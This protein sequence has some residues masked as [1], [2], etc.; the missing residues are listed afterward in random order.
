VALT[1]KDA[2]RLFQVRPG[3]KF[4][5]KRHDPG[6]AGGDEFTELRRPELKARAVTFLEKN[7][8]EL[9][10]AQELLYASDRYSVLIVLQAMD[11]AGKDGTIKH[12]L[13]GVNP[14]GCQVFSFKKPSDEEL[15]HNF[16]WRYMRA[17]PERGR[18]GIFNRSYYEDVLVVRVHPEILDHQ[19]LPPGKRGRKFW[20]SRFDDINRF[21]R[22]LTRNGTLV[23]KFFLHLSRKEQKARFMERLDK[24]EKHWKFSFADLKER[25][26]WDAYQA[27]FEDMLRNTSTD[28]APWWVIPADHK[29]VTRALVAGITTESIRRLGLKFPTVTAEQRRLLV[30]ARRQLTSGK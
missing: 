22:H 14:Q 19:K 1:Y 28:W 8:E 15:D 21:E 16:L 2:R 26:F 20:E 23:L 5:L 27:A 9:A 6:W 24:E 4:R 12:V 25:S 30:R 17:L 7:I 29:W 10:E 18:I 13:S 11:A 3:R